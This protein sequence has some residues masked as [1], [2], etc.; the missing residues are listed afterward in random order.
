[1][2]MAFKSPF[3][4]LVMIF[5]RL[6]QQTQKAGAVVHNC[7]PNYAGSRGRRVSPRQACAALELH[8]GLA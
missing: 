7:T 3:N 8:S 6:L 4:I 2:I 1:M 5:I